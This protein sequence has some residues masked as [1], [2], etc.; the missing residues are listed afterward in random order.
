[1]L[2]NS[3]EVLAVAAQ[4]KIGDRMVGAGHPTYF[5]ADIAANHD[6]DLNR[7]LDLIGMAAEAGAC[8]AKF[9]N[10][11]AETIVS[12]P[13]FRSLGGGHSHQASWTKSVFDVYR[14]ASLP[15][16]WTPELFRACRD[17][18]IHYL[19]A[20]YDLSLIDAL[21]Q[22]VCAWKVGSG[23]ITWH[24]A[25]ERMAQSPKPVL[26]AT[27]AST[28]DEVTAAL[29]VARRWTDRIVLL[30][31]NTN[32]TGSRDNFRYVD[33]RVLTTFRELFSD[34]VLG[35]SDHT[36]GHAAVLGAVT[37]GAAVVEKHFT[38]DTTRAGPDHRFSLDTQAWREMVERTRDLEAA[39]GSGVKRL[40]DN[41]RETV[42][43]QRRAVRA[44]V[45]LA[46]GTLLGE[47]HLAVLRPCPEEGLPPYRLNEL[48]GRRLKREVSR[49]DLVGLADVT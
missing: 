28:L 15:M 16:D 11:K 27:G 47:E 1:M 31:C 10:F 46:R 24:A 37:L 43:L 8:A 2:N 44:A 41:E 9:Q 29:A 14:D 13:G 36:P 39:L 35:L 38:D 19:T 25:V 49:G 20:P 30:Q 7:A 3:T 32:Y 33:L 18:G 23:D 21:E 22:F 26:I 42:V 34:L 40:M 5:I 12:D 48:L 45:D 6:G 4:I 17:A